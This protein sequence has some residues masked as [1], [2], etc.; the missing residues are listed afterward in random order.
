[1]ALIDD[2]RRQ[3]AVP[4]SKMTELIPVARNRM[5]FLADQVYE[6]VLTTVVFPENGGDIRY[7]GK[8]TESNIAKT[9]EISNGPVREAL[10]RLRQEGWIK[11]YPN[12]G[13]YM[14]DFRDPEIAREIYRFRVSLETGAFYTLAKSITAEQLCQ[15]EVI[16]ESLEKARQTSEI[17]GFRKADIDF[18]LKVVE[19]AGGESYQAM[20]RPKLL[21]WHAMVYHVVMQY[22]GDERYRKTLEAPGT[23]SHHE[24]YEALARHDSFEAARLIQ[25]HFYDIPQLM[26]LDGSSREDSSEV[27]LKSMYREGEPAGVDSPYTGPG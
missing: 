15:L 20:Y 26:R 16:I 1:M 8:I 27:I 14:V 23:S 19:L 12:R 9:L 4:L 24:L 10:F 6:H 25:K 22:L 2:L 21:Q 11:T 5:V 7:G 13:S 17:V 18:H 3:A